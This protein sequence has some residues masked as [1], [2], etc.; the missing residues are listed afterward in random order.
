MQPKFIFS[1]LSLVRRFQRWMARPLEETQITA[2]D[3]DV[4]DY[5]RSDVGLAPHH[6][7]PTQRSGDPPTR[8]PFR[9]L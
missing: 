5:L 1:P 7:K 4:P 8:D 9:L 2:R 3:A 6:R